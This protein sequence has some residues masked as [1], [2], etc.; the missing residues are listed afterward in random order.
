MGFGSSLSIRQR[1]SIIEQPINQGQCLFQATSAPRGPYLKCQ[2]ESG[3][4]YRLG[5]RPA[6]AHP[7][8]G[9]GG[10]PPDRGRRG[11][12]TCGGDRGRW[13]FGRGQDRGRGRIEERRGKEVNTFGWCARTGCRVINSPNYR[14]EDE[15]TPN[16]ATRL[17]EAEE[18]FTFKKHPA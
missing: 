3:H 9:W 5:D 6:P 11:D 14:S 16:P 15:P 8:A 13:G 10:P 12:R 17:G 4:R 2:R 1:A 7:T 18:A